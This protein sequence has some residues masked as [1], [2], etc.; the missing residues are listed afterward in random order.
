LFTFTSC[1]LSNSSSKQ[2]FC[3]DFRKQNSVLPIVFYVPCIWAFVLCVPGI[4]V[5]INHHKRQQNGQMCAGRTETCARKCMCEHQALFFV[6]CQLKW[7][8]QSQKSFFLIWLFDGFVYKGLASW[9]TRSSW[10]LLSAVFLSA[11]S[12]IHISK[13][14]FKCQIPSQNVSFYL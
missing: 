12:L 2:I 4:V 7:L 8:G 14:G 6:N 10:T 5:F 9:H 1:F 11:N 13:M 3:F